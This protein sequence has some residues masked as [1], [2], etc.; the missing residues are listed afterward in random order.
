[1]TWSVFFN[2]LIQCPFP[3]RGKLNTTDG[4]ENRRGWMKIV[5]FGGNGFIGQKIC[6]ELVARNH[7]VVS[8]SRSGQPQKAR[9]EWL[10]QVQWVQ[11]DVLADKEWH[12]VTA[13]ADWLVNCIGVLFEKKARNQTYE[14]LI[15]APVT[16]I[17]DYLES[18]QSTTPLLSISANHVPFFLK[19]YLV[20]KKRTEKMITTR[21]KRGKVIYPGLVTDP[22]RPGSLIMG[23]AINLLTKLPVIHGFFRG[24]DVISR[25]ELAKEI[26]HVLEGYESPY[27]QRRG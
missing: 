17:L 4:S 12:E 15:E 27:T 26:C 10:A 2:S 8:V 9:G 16:I 13:D 3:K 21:C 7:Q 23:W 1:M 19:R 11:S 25:T 18:Q 14:R 22:S 20:A 5:V 24:Y 6:Q